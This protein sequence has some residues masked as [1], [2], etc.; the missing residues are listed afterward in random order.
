MKK[1]VDDIRLMIKVCDLYYNQNAGQQQI[2]NLLSISR[3]TV[4]RLLSSARDRGI[5]NIQISNLNSI[6]YWEMECQLQEK[7]RLKDVIIVE[8]E[9]NLG[10]SAARYLE[11]NIK[12]D[13]IVGV[14]MGATLYEVVSQITE[15]AASNVTFV[16]LIGGMGHLR[17]ELHSNNLAESLSRKFHGHF[18]PLHAPA[19]VSSASVRKELMREESVAEA[20]RIG[21]QVEL[22]VVGIGF[23]NEKSSIK[24]TGYFKEKEVESL[25]ERL[26]AGEICMQFYDIYGST[27]AYKNDNYVI[28]MELRKLRK[29]PFSVGIAG[30]TEKCRAIQGAIQGRYI[31]VLITDADCASA[32]LENRGDG[33]G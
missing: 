31:N 9:Q 21:E 17:M 16:P 24:A 10:S 15:P 30:G 22:A 18:V 28:G 7:Y 26:V 5:V 2:A 25:R 6:R 20:L 29:V 8:S 19:R 12:G 33:H 32:L 1:V 14:S 4:S 13:S 11:A 3:P 27:T 23:P